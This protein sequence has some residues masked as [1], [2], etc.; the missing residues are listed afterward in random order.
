[1]QKTKRQNTGDLG[2]AIVE[3]YCYCPKC[4]ST[5][6]TLKRLP[7]NFKCADIIC[8]FCGFLAQVKTKTANDLDTID[9]QI[10]GAGWAPQK[11]RMDAGIYFPLYFV[12][13]TKDGKE[14]SVFYLPADYQSPEMFVPSVRQIKNRKPYEMFNYRFGDIKSSMI[15]VR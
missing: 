3:K 8:D 10:A 5:T 15:K 12:K 9:N 7:P 11:A 13:V 14:F 2:E 6:K 1:M 4:K